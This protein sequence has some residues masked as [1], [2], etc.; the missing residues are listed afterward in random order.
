M[1]VETV[2][3]LA[4]AR[5]E[6]S[7]VL[8]CEPHRNLIRSMDNFHLFFS[9]RLRKLSALILLLPVPL[10]NYEVRSEL[11]SVPGPG[12]DAVLH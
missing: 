5:R 2:R 4:T 6:T 7:V 9:Y 10:M 12:V 8:V 11:A 3:R 1:N